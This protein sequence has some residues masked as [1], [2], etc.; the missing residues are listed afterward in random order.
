MSIGGGRDHEAIGGV[1][2][3]VDLRSGGAKADRHVARSRPVD[4]SEDQALDLR[5]VRE[6][7][8]M[9]PPDAPN[10]DLRQ[11]HQARPPGVPARQRSMAT[12][13]LRPMAAASLGGSQLVSCSTIIQP[14]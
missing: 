9:Q 14:P 8:G 11:S 1:H 7:L 13:T 10:A 4:V 12:R 6:H 2:S 3:F 5:V